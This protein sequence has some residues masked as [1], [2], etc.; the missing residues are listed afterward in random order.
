MINDLDK[1]QERKEVV[2]PYDMKY[3]PIKT[4]KSEVNELD[5]NKRIDEYK[6]QLD[7][8]I[9]DMITQF[10]IEENQLIRQIKKINNPEEKKKQEDELIEVKDA[11][12]KKISRQ[13]E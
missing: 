5:A 2:I 3:S 9:Y 8:N 6:S 11:N 7:H 10:N 12:E 13:K 4:M 1:D